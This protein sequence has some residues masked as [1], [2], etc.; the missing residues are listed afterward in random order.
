M[1]SIDVS[2]RAGV[3]AFIDLYAEVVNSLDLER[4]CELLTDDIVWS[5]PGLVSPA[6]GKDAVV[7][8]LAPIY[9][10]MPDTYVE[11]SDPPHRT[12]HGDL[13]AWGWRTTG[14]ADGQPFD[15]LGVDLFQIRDGRI[16]AVR[17]FYHSALQP[18]TTAYLDREEASAPSPASSTSNAT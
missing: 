16:A 11:D 17:G 13:V 7:A 8:Y 12:A 5:D 14:T 3:D 4:Y 6:H 2:T 18:I 1:P 9:Q 15:L 10:A